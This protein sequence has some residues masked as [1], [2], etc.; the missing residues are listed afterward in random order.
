MPKQKTRK[1]IKKRIKLTKKGKATAKK[2]GRGHLLTSKSRK[3]KRSLS[4]KNVFGKRDS[5]KIREMMP[6]D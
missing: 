6:Y 5:E 2:A 1:A 4:S 3:R